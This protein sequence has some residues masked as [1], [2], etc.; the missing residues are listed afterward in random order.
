MV[1]PCF[2]S[3]GGGD[4]ISF[5]PKNIIMNA[6]RYQRVLEE[7]MLNSYD[8]HD[9]FHFQQDNAP[10]HKAKRIDKFLR[11]NDVEPLPWPA[12]SPDLNPAENAWKIMKGKV[13]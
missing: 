5:L 13:C 9:A 1:W 7:K 8:I 2:S 6:E 10:C 3:S 11:N 4:S 12:N